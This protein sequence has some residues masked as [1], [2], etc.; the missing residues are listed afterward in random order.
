MK[1]VTQ[2]S[3]F[4][5]RA[6]EDETSMSILEHDP[7]ARRLG[8]AIQKQDPVA[9]SYRHAGRS[10]GSARSSLPSFVCS[11]KNVACHGYAEAAAPPILVLIQFCTSSLGAIP[12]FR[13]TFR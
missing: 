8:K 6:M 12:T 1:N 11:K 13:A 5:S 7:I 9:M 10:K 2:D 3:N 4:S